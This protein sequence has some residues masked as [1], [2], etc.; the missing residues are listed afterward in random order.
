MQDGGRSGLLYERRYFSAWK[1]LLFLEKRP[2][3]FAEPRGAL[4]IVCSWTLTYSDRALMRT[5]V[6]SS[7]SWAF[8]RG[9]D[10]REREGREVEFVP[11]G[12]VFRSEREGGDAGEDWS[13]T[14]A[15]PGGTE[16]MSR[17]AWGKERVVLRYAAAE[18]QRIWTGQEM[19]GRMM[20]TPI[21]SCTFR[22]NCQSVVETGGCTRACTA[23]PKNRRTA[24]IE[25]Q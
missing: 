3:P 9:D 20:K 11:E 14:R 18:N 17:K 12:D 23:L 10:A 8:L 22:R 25:Y 19:E 24:S 5:A 4:A 1:S 2:L 15:A 7:K 13:E 16:R 6:S 21:L